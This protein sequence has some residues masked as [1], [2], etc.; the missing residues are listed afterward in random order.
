MC[1]RDN[2]AAKLKLLWKTSDEEFAVPGPALAAPP[3]GIVVRKAI[4]KSL[5]RTYDANSSNAFVF[6]SKL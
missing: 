3:L 5:L 2:S 4:E 6:W 1:L